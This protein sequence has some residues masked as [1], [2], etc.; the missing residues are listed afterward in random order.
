MLICNTWQDKSRA[1]EWG[2]KKSDGFI[3]DMNTQQRK[4]CSFATV[5]FLQVGYC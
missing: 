5:Q 3:K 1:N 4:G 2:K